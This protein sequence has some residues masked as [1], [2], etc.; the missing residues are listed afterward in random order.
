MTSATFLSNGRMKKNAIH[1]LIVI[2]V[3]INFCAVPFAVA[4][5]DTLKTI[6]Y[7]T[8]YKTSAGNKVL[9]K[10]GDKNI[11]VR[12]FL[13]SYEYGPAFTKREKDSKS[14]YLNYMINEKL[15]ALYGY[16]EKV[17]TSNQVN[18]VL[19]A[20]TG[21]IA[22]DEMFMNEIFNKI[23]VPK[24]ELDSALVQKGI[25]YDI[26]W[27]Y[28][29][30]EKMLS[31]YQQQLKSGV[32]FDSLFSLQLLNDS[33]HADQ[34][35]MKVDMFKLQNENPFLAKVVDTLKVNEISAPIKAPDGYY[36]IKVDDIWKKLILTETERN[37]EL[38]DAGLVIKRNKSDGIS[39]SY[40]QKL[41]LAHNPVIQGKAFDILRSY[42]GG[43]V[44]PKEKY[45]E[46][47]LGERLSKELDSLKGENY[48]GMG[49]VSLTKG[50]ISIDDFIYWYKLRDAYLKFDEN[51]F[52]GFSASLE[53]M[54]W[55]MVRDHLL[56]A[57]AY[58]KGYQNKPIVKQQSQWWKDKIVYAV[59][60]DQLANSVGLNIES[61][62]SIKMADKD[63]ELTSKI[64]HKIIE[65]KRKYKIQ[66][67]E[68]VL[69]EIR[70]QDSDD[71]RAV[72][73]YMV[74]KGGTYPHPAFPSID[75][76][77]QSWE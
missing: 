39:D 6:D 42:M 40:V 61:P 67:N 43:F 63:Q 3:I 60:R 64:L 66:I 26:R 12:E 36:I 41:M 70:V 55:R 73:Y 72:D 23:V 10:V 18:S 34:R 44:L 1:I 29:R 31:A 68:N 28:A 50:A 11:T 57:S 49:L 19:S 59:V 74:K 13:T 30:N 21:D 45:T 48:G 56:V 77:W 54:I 16:S 14:R 17:D 69:K 2:T 52:N 7:N 4:K 51:D 76:S 46:W 24:K 20:I 37:K 65:L 22:S 75:F 8:A 71:P 35:S 53:K 47:K 38:H 62:S 5:E 58:A 32:T 25:N 9:A 27:L 15:L 33:V